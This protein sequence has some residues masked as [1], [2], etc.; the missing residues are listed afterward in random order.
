M[1]ESDWLALGTRPWGLVYQADPFFAALIE[2][3]F[4]IVYREADVVDSGAA[5]GDEFSDRRV[6]FRRLQQ[7]DQRLA[8]FESL[9]SCTVGIGYLDLIHSEYVPEEWELRLNRR[10]R[11]S[12]VRDSGSLWGFV[13]H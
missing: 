9:D 2:H 1:N 12:N 4:Q 6:V 3:S 7:L 10:Q 11:D 13:L 5:L 8:R